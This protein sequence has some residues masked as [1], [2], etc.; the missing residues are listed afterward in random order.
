MF[1]PLKN[2]LGA[3]IDDPGQ[4]VMVTTQRQLPVQRFTA[5]HELGHAALGH[6]ASFDEEDVLTRAL[7]DEGS[8]FD[9]REIQANAF[10][11]ALLTPQW[12]IVQ[13]MQRQGWA[14]KELADPVVV[15][16]LSLRMG[17]S[18]A[19]TCYAL[20]DCKGIDRPTCDKLMEANKKKRAIKQSLAKPYTPGNW[21]G[22]VWLV[23]ER[24]NG[25][26]LEGSHSDLVVV[27]VREHASSGY[28]WQFGELA[29]AG[30]AIREDGRESEGSQHIGGVVFRTVIAEADGGASGHVCLRELRPWQAAGT[31]LN[32]MELHVDLSGPVSAGLLS[33]Q[34]E[35]L[36]EV[37]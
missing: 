27:K 23:T 35:A 18:F 25:M 22:D 34:R 7:F 30:L 21:Y 16:Q 12:L 15:Y 26:V 32:S 36:L 31:P 33:V 11:T 9:T 6:E 10:A 5:A 13:H 14:R 8:R 24:D 3:Y 1:R 4:G 37:A 17:S 2:L 20:L 28:M 19:A 29:E